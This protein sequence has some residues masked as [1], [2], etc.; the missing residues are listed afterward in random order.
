MKSI[1]EEVTSEEIKDVF[2]SMEAL[3]APGPDSYHAMFIQ[4][5]WDTIGDSI[6]SFI[7]KCLR[8]HQGLTPLMIWMWL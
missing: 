2:F 1:D 8:I 3:K 6:C 7:K 5:Q 4:S